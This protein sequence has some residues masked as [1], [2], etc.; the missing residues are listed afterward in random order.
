MVAP[1]VLGAAGVAAKVGPA[2]IKTAPTIIKGVKVAGEAFTAAKTT[3]KLAKAGKQTLDH[4]RTPKGPE[5]KTKQ[6]MGEVKDQTTSPQQ[7]LQPQK[8]HHS[9][10]HRHVH[11][12]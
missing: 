7:S 6:L 2:I 12:K 1:L 3:V 10:H 5:A 11:K 8:P 9:H 4:A